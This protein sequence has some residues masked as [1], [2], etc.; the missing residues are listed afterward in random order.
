VCGEGAANAVLGIGEV[1]VVVSGRVVT[2][3][4][5]IGERSYINGSSLSIKIINQ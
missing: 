3:N 1:E 2:E 5:V 4:G